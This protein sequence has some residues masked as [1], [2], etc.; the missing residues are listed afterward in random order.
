MTR[1][2]AAKMYFDLKQGLMRPS[3]FANLQ[4]LFRNHI[5]PQIGKVQINDITNR[6]LKNFT[7]H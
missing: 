1:D 6:E 7:I 3:S 2:E 5:Q 4:R